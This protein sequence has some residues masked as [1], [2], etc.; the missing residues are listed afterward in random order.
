MILV[1]KLVGAVIFSVTIGLPHELE[2]SWK[3]KGKLTEKRATSA[4]EVE[5]EVWLIEEVITVFSIESNGM[6]PYEFAPGGE[7]QF[8]SFAESEVSINPT[9]VKPAELK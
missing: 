1:G 3:L 4:L 6:L 2:G 9:L 7:L 8:N 5:T